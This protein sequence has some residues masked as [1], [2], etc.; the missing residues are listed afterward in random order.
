VG[1]GEHFL[2]AFDMAV[3]EL[4]TRPLG[5]PPLRS[6]PS[7]RRLALERFPHSQTHRM[8]EGAGVVQVLSCWHQRRDRAAL[9]RRLQGSS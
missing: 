4:A 8:E 9:M 6:W 5:S 3:G 1:L 7:L 2:Q